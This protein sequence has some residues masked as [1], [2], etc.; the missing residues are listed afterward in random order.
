MAVCECNVLVAQ[1]L[2]YPTQLAT[3]R[4]PPPFLQKGD[5]G[6]HVLR[7]LSDAPWLNRRRPGFLY[8][9]IEFEQIP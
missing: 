1:T 5:S 4:H 7:G 2:I 6:G 3:H 8:S 9:I